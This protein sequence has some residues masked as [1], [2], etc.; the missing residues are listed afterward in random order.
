MRTRGRVSPKERTTESVL[1]SIDGDLILFAD[2]V[3]CKAPWLVYFDV[4][5]EVLA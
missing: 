2:Y 3:S 5:G 4:L 1:K